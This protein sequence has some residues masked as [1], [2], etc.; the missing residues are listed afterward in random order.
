MNVEYRLTRVARA[1]AAVEDCRC[2]LRWVFE[3]AEKYSFDTERIIVSGQSAGGHLALMTGMAASEES[4]DRNCPGRPVK[5][6]AIVNWF[7]ITDVGD[8]LAGE[9][10]LGRSLSAA[11][12]LSTC[13]SQ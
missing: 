5:V 11:P 8:L 6:A 12:R 4:F 7:G 13:V 2:A 10:P 3:N 1:P 9:S